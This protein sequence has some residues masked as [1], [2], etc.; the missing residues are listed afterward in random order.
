MTTGTTDYSG[1]RVL[2]EVAAK[3][4]WNI[5]EDMHGAKGDGFELVAYERGATQIMIG[6][7]PSNAAVYVVKDHGCPTEE[8]A[9]GPL[10]LITA[11]SWM[12]SE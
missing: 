6:W 1:R 12:E 2:A 8:L 9:S 3:C 7:T 11:R 10:A 4:G 5:H